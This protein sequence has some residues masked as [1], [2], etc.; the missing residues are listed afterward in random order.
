MFSSKYYNRYREDYFDRK[1][2]GAK[3]KL[4][5]F[6]TDEFQSISYIYNIPERQKRPEKLEIAVNVKDVSFHYNALNP[7][8]NKISLQ[9]PRG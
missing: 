8:L 4:K 3:L 1:Y 6:D 9:V 5:K 7:I 2:Y